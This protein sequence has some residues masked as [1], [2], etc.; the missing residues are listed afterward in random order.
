MIQDDNGCDFV[1]LLPTAIWGSATPGN[2]VPLGELR[3][4]WSIAPQG[5][6]NLFCA[7]N[8]KKIRYSITHTVEDTHPSNAFGEGRFIG[9]VKMGPWIYAW[10]N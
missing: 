5:N 7:S 4:Y 9:E 8:Q 6:G 10:G 1:D 2:P 3:I